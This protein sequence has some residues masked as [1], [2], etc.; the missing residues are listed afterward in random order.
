MRLE[1]MMKGRN[2]QT[3]NEEKTENLEMREL[4]SRIRGANLNWC[5]MNQKTITETSSRGAIRYFIQHKNMNL[6]LLKNSA[7]LEKPCS[8]K[9][10]QLIYGE[11][12]KLTTVHVPLS[13]SVF[14]DYNKEV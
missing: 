10:A 8:T 14:H 2:T 7:R 1:V 13:D 12:I 6:R 5:F 9:G 4:L 3:R 11:D